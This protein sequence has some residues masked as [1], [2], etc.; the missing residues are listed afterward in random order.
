MQ[1]TVCCAPIHQVELSA[2]GNQGGGPRLRYRGWGQTSLCSLA[3]SHQGYACR[4]VRPADHLGSKPGDEEYGLSSFVAEL[5]N[6]NNE[7]RLIYSYR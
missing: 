5:T 3:P 4:P 7:N 2:G 6:G 1:L